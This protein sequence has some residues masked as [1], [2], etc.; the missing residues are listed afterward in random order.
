MKGGRAP[1]PRRYIPGADAPANVVPG[2]QT[3]QGM[4]NSITAG[5]APNFPR[6]ATL[7][8]ANFSKGGSRSTRKGGRRATRIGRRRLRRRLRRRGRRR[9]T[10]KGGGVLATA[11]LPFGLF[12]LQRLLGKKYTRKL[13]HWF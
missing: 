12:G 6:A 11:A 13:R 1:T 7:R 10:R 8:A 9:S 5:P 2:G 3:P 4:P